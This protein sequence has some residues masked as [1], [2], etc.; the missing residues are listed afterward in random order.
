V[1][2][3][4]VVKI[5]PVRVL[6]ENELDLPGA[7]P[8]LYQLFA[9]NRQANVIVALDIDQPLQP[10]PLGEAFEHSLA[11]LP[12]PACE[13]A[14]YPDIEGTVLSVGHDVD[15]AASHVG[16]VSPETARPQAAAWMAGSSPAMTK[17]ERGSL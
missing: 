6:C 3:Q 15:P 4:A 16:F 14:R 5:I 10:V 8:V 9:L 7:R 17:K 2:G 13:I 1:D 12:N 11:M